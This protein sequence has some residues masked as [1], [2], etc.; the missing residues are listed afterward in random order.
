[1]KFE[2]YCRDSSRSWIFDDSSFKKVLLTLC[3]TSDNLNTRQIVILYRNFHISFNR[4]ETDA[5]WC[6]KGD[7]AATLTL[8]EN[9]EK[10]ETRIIEFDVDEKEG[11]WYRARAIINKDKLCIQTE[12]DDNWVTVLNVNIS[13]HYVIIE[14]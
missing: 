4:G 13:G 3:V 9:L 7:D 6:I 11:R 8:E 1:M 14:V 10:F 5:V 2:V 12:Q